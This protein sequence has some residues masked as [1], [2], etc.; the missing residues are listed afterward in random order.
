MEPSAAPSIPSHAPERTGS[1][2]LVSCFLILGLLL[3]AGCYAMDYYDVGA[4][5]PGTRQRRKT[6]GIVIESEIHGVTIEE[7]LQRIRAETGISLDWSA[8]PPEVRARRTMAYSRGVRLGDFISTLT[9][10]LSTFDGEIDTWWKPVGR[11][12]DIT[13]RINRKADHK[14]ERSPLPSA[15]VTK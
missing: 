3:G 10:E 6:A 1:L 14:S 12:S 13:F 4:E 9:R 11:V 2:G 15:P 7:A 5:Y 8:L